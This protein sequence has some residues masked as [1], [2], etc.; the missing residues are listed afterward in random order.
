MNAR[1]S[2]VRRFRVPRFLSEP[3]GRGASFGCGGG[4]FLGMIGGEC[5]P[6]GLFNSTPLNKRDML[7]SL[8]TAFLSLSL[9]THQGLA[10]VWSDSG[11]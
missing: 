5:G 8:L 4:G 3:G 9:Q 11:G 6:A 7:L 2:I 10:P 1:I